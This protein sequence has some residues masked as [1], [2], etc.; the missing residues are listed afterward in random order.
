VVCFALAPNL[1]DLMN[2]PQ[3]T[4][5]LRLLCI[6]VIF[7]GISTVLSGTLTRRFLQARRFVA[8]SSNF[9]LGTTVTII[10]AVAG[11]GAM[12]LAIGRIAG[13]IVGMVLIWIFSPVMF[14]PGWEREEARELVRAMPVAPW[15]KTQ[16]TM[17]E[18]VIGSLP[19]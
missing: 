7:D 13:G 9:A 19:G 1:A 6:Q 12:S 4:G 18:V 5:V 3:A 2:A 8:D 14:G 16:K 17:T 15:A 11:R 10:L